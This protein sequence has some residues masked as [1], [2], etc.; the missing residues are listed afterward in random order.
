MATI[1]WAVTEAIQSA[2]TTELNSLAN[3]AYSAVSAVIDNEADLYQFMALELVLA[4]LTPTGTPSCSVY[5]LPAVDDTNYPDGGGATAPPLG[6]L[7][8]VFDLSTSAT[9]KRRTAVNIA[10]PPY[11]FKLLV[12]NSAGPAL[13]SS[14]NTLKYSR[15]NQQVS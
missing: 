12:L 10:I 6:T 15:Y 14:G 9:A 7:I 4:S 8:A 5:L 1:K 3:A 2:L 13:A 11:K